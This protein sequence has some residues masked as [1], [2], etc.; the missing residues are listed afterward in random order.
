MLKIIGTNIVIQ[1]FFTKAMHRG[2]GNAPVSVP[3]RWFRELLG[4]LKIWLLG[5]IFEPKL[6]MFSKSYSLRPQ[7]TYFVIDPSVKNIDWE[8]LGRLNLLMF[9]KHFWTQMIFLN[10]LIKVKVINPLQPGVVFLYPLKTSEK[11]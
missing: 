5:E 8:P 4:I 10:L 9:V 7:S 3:Q 6:S 11:I 2:Q 1:S